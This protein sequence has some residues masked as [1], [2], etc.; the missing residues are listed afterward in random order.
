MKRLSILTVIFC[1]PF[2]INAQVTLGVK[3]GSSI[4]TMGLEEYY[5]NDFNSRQANV[6]LTGQTGELNNFV[7]SERNSFTGGVYAHIQLS[8]LFSIQPE[9]IFTGKGFVLDY[10][11]E[12]EVSPNV[13][14]LNV[15]DIYRF[16]YMDLPILFRLNGKMGHLRPYVLAGGAPS[17]LV[18]SRVLHKQR[19]LFSSTSEFITELNDEGFETDGNDIDLITNAKGIDFSVIGGLG[20]DYDVSDNISFKMEGRYTYGF[21]DLYNPGIS[22]QSYTSNVTGFGI[23]IGV[24][25]RL[26]GGARM[27]LPVEEAVPEED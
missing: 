20:F 12:R 1:T 13:N 23:F 22:S 26:N 8:K 6:Q 16:N 7:F 5:T 27:C 14:T 10:E 19:N 24:G 21:N 17:F 3:M 18:A 4:T 2:L 15:T 9:L 11:I 25:F